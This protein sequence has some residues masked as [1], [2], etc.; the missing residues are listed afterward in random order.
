MYTTSLGGFHLFGVLS[1]EMCERCTV[2]L[3]PDNVIRANPNLD[4][5]LDSYIY[6]L[7]LNLRVANP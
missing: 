1:G 2:A 3:Q 6:N 5:R 7:M 4:K